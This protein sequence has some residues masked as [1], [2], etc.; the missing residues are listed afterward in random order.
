MDT[1]EATIQFID[2]NIIST[3][4]SVGSSQIPHVVFV[5]YN[6]LLKKKKV[7]KQSKQYF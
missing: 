3:V 1:H 6:P 2:S 5:V 7:S 4:E